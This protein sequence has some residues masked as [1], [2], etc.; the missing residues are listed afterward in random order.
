MTDL[1]P[2]DQEHEAT[3]VA[4]LLLRLF[5]MAFGVLSLQ[6]IAVGL[7]T[8]TSEVVLWWSL[9]FWANV[10]LLVAARYVDIRYYG[11]ETVDFEPADLGHWRRHTAALTLAAFAVWIIA[12]M[13]GG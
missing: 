5:W 3:P 7:W 2:K 4:G 11:G 9:L 6:A 8:R 10:G 13:A 1:P 12:V